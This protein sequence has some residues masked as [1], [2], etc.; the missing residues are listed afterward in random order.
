MCASTVFSRKQGTSASALS[1]CR[2]VLLML[3]PWS[4]ACRLVPKSVLKPEQFPQAVVEALRREGRVRGRLGGL[5]L[6]QA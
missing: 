2:F 6:L 1:L 3:P 5:V 4:L